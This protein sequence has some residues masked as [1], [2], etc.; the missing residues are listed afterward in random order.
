M[1]SRIYIYLS[2]RREESSQTLPPSS[3]LFSSLMT[4]NVPDL[5][6]APSQNLQAIAADCVTQQTSISIFSFALSYVDLA[7]LGVLCEYTGMLVEGE[8][9][10]REKRVSDAEFHISVDRR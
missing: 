8:K 10:G 9:R 1:H 4:L 5:F 6:K 7:Y 3:Y 2:K